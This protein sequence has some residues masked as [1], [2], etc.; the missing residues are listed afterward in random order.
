MSETQKYL[1][2]KKTPDTKLCPLY[3]FKDSQNYSTVIELES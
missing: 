2:K 3:M 1:I